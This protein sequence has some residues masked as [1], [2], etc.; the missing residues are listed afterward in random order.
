MR[1]N[2][3][4]SD[5]SIERLLLHSVNGLGINRV[6][7]QS[8][9]FDQESPLVETRLLLSPMDIFGCAPR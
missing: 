7:N 2:G 5:A 1:R 3:N 6:M 8:D 9:A 4:F